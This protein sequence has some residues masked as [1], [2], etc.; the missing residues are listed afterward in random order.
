MNDKIKEMTD[1]V[2]EINYDSLIEKSLKHVVVEALKIAEDA[3]LDL[4]MVSPN[5]NP[6]LNVA[7]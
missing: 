2:S 1:F 4:V 6:P 7:G 5:A 3:E